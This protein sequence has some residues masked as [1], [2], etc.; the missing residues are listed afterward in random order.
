MDLLAFFRKAIDKVPTSKTSS[1]THAHTHTTTTKTHK[2]THTHTIMMTTAYIHLT[3]LS[4]II[5][6]HK[7]YCYIKSPSMCYSMTDYSKLHPTPYVGRAPPGRCGASNLAQAHSL[8]VCP[9]LIFHRSPVST[10][11]KGTFVSYIRLWSLKVY[12]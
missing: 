12:Q 6:M 5:Y 9:F 4:Y 7:L 3:N 1:C 8:G 11:S 10:V 2:Q